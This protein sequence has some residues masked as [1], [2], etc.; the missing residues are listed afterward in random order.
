MNSHSTVS[1]SKEH[2]SERGAALITMLLIS[3]LLLAAGGALIMTSALSG[4]NSTDSS[5][6]TQA[7]YAAEAGVQ[8]T[9]NVLRG[10][11]SAIT[12]RQAVATP[13]LAGWLSYNTTYNRVTLSDNYNP[14]SGLAYNVTVT[15][16]DNTGTV[17]F[18][19]TGAFPTTTTGNSLTYQV[20]T[21]NQDKALI[22][23]TPPTSPTTVSLSGSVPFGSFLIT[24]DKAAQFDNF[25]IGNSSIPFNLTISQTSPYPSSSTSP[26]VA[27]I[28]CK[29]TGKISSTSTSNNVKIEFPTL[30]NNTNYVSGVSY[31]RAAASYTIA[32][33][34]STAVSPVTVTAPQPY[35]V[36]VKVIGYGPHASEKHLQMMVHRF[37]FD[38]KANAAITLRSADDGT[39]TMSAFA[40]G[41]SS[42]YKY[43]GNDNAGGAAVPA[44]A[45]TNAAN[46]TQASG[47]VSGN[48]QITGSSQV[49]TAALSELSTLLQTAQGARDAVAALRDKAKNEY[50]PTSY[51]GETYD[52]YFPSG[53]TPDT[54]GTEA[55]PVITFV[56]GNAALPPGGGAG[57]LVVTGILDMRGNADFKGVI[58]VLGTGQVLRD[59]GGNGV[60]LGA[61][62]VASFGSSGDFTAPSFNSNGSGTADIFYDSKWVEKALMTSAPSVRG[63]SEY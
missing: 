42:Q 9:L 62:F 32:Y 14:L 57:M 26:T 15:D 23:Y 3:M 31:A 38:F 2:R 20:G 33:N 41:N 47:V 39:S 63:L 12:F 13:S 28:A 1:N 45:V 54:F 16:P 4:T 18:S 11:V 44:F 30:A 21:T 25:D 48:P 60:T 6:E 29:L 19:V 50:W 49:K 27:V 7:Y 10:N 55:N 36:L 34:A 17:I 46:Y 53:T 58:L 35:R 37:A 56:D 59:G 8:S 24:P 61:M 51:T 43:S 52:R 22:T 5:A 40:V